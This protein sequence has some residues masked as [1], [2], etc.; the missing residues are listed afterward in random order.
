MVIRCDGGCADM[1]ACTHGCAH[2]FACVHIG[3][4]VCASQRLVH[5]C[6]PMCTYMC[7]CMHAQVLMHA[8]TLEHACGHMCP[9]VCASG[10][11]CMCTCACKVEYSAV[12]CELGI[13]RY[14]D[15]QMVSKGHHMDIKIPQYPDL[16][17]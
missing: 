2:A 1:C 15:V 6:M 10:C 17:H 7:V 13:L 8:R 16:I 9:H 4:H 14:F 11:A 12:V 5:M 3:T